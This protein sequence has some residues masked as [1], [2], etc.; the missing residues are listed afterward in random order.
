MNAFKITTTLLLGLALWQPMSATADEPTT[1]G[2]TP[3]RFKPK[4]RS[5][6]SKDARQ[7][8][9][10][11]LQTLDRHVQILGQA[12]TRLRASD[13]GSPKSAVKISVVLLLLQ[14]DWVELSATADPAITRLRWS[15]SLDR[16]RKSN[17]ADKRRFQALRARHEIEELA[18]KAVSMET[19]SQPLDAIE[20]EELQQIQAEIKELIL[21]RDEYEDDVA[22]H[23]E[24]AARHLAE[25][26]SL[27]TLARRFHGAR[28]IQA[29]R[30][31]RIA[32]GAERN[33]LGALAEDVRK[34][35]ELVRKAIA[36]VSRAYEDKSDGPA[37]TADI[38]STRGNHVTSHGVSVAPAI[39][40]GTPPKPAKPSP[41][42]M[43][44]LNKARERDAKK[45]KR[46][47]TKTDTETSEAEAGSEKNK[48]EE[49]R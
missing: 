24:Q 33:V 36:L 25:L 18:D 10:E 47:N 15:L 17:L 27:S 6:N 8:L 48:K 39:V 41:G 26:N 7:Q 32:D 44:E 9:A 16:Q 21:M 30:A 37:T 13:D 31:Q 14:K 2:R 23:E 35:R 42:V 46:S 28:R 22:T 34:D 45:A 19:N 11:K 5:P 40:R 38:P 4:L 12:V 49:S 1:K 3:L 29:I 20:S 43:A